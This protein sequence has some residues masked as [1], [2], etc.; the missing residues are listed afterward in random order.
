MEK[1]V[2]VPPAAPDM[3]PCLKCVESTVHL[4]GKCMKCASVVVA[5]E[6]KKTAARHDA[7]YFL[8]VVAIIGAIAVAYRVNTGAWPTFGDDKSSTHKP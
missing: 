2:V 1:E 4:D 3:R 5:W 7:Y 6:K 8:L